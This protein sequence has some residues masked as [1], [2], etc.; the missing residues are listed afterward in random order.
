MH[1][2]GDD[3]LLMPD[4]FEDE[5]PGEWELEQYQI[6]LVNLEPTI[7]SEMKKTRP[8]VIFHRMK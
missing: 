7:G 2:N 5:N 6:V 8:Y 4:V 1:A 3:K